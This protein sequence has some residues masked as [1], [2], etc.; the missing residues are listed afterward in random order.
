MPSLCAPSSVRSVDPYATG[1]FAK[2]NP[3]AV[4]SHADF[5]R[6]L[7]RVS[8]DFEGT[9]QQE[10]ENRTLS[11]FLEALA[12]YA[13]DYPQTYVNEGKTFPDPPTW[14]SVARLISGATGYE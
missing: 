6:F 12:R 13:D 14:E 5:V 7:R 1:R 8:R 3:D 11:D 10:W 9:G 2:P 4:R